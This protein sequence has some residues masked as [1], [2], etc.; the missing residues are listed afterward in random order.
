MSSPQTKPGFLDRGFRK[1]FRLAY[2]VEEHRRKNRWSYRLACAIPSWLLL[3][4]LAD[5]WGIDHL[6]NPSWWFIPSPISYAVTLKFGLSTALATIFTEIVVR[7]I[8]PLL[9]Y[10]PQTIGMKNVGLVFISEDPDES[11]RLIQ[12]ASN[13]HD[14]AKKILVICISGRH[15]FREES[16]V[17]PG[18]ARLSPL[19]EA[20]KK[21]QLEV[22]MP[23]SNPGNSTIKNRYATYGVNYKLEND[24]MTVQD[25]IREIDDGKR[26]LRNNGNTVHE[27]DILCMWR[28]IIFS[29]LCIVQNY[30]PN[31]QGQ[32]SFLAPIMVFEKGDKPTPWIRY[33]ETFCEM[34]ELIKAGG[35][36]DVKNEGPAA[37][38][39]TPIRTDP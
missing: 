13:E 4:Y 10:I 7:A 29:H 22:L 5:I 23:R 30:F 3:L 1:L 20:G 36:R 32:H 26:F 2:A 16:M 34:F 35:P 6:K 28:L 19:H 24:L 17:L 33:Y 27:H 8:L 14:P 31:P 18:G 37:P 9:L 11:W 38:N 39:P 25:F 12:K 15:L 21:G